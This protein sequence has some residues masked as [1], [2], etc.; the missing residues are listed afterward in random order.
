MGSFAPAVRPLSF[1]LRPVVVD[2]F[3]E[4]EIGGAAAVDPFECAPAESVR[5]RVREVDVVVAEA[6]PEPAAPE[7]PVA[8]VTWLEEDGD[9]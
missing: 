7:E 3:T 8:V 9:G 5:A 2:A 1:G 4:G 6:D